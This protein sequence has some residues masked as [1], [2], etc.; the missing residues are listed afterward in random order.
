MASSAFRFR[1]GNRAHPPAAAHRRR[2]S[3]PV[4]PW[5]DRARE[6]PRRYKRPEEV[7]AD[8]GVRSEHVGARRRLSDAVRQDAGL[9][10]FCRFPPARVGPGRAQGRQERRGQALLRDL[11]ERGFRKSS[12]RVGRSPKKSTTRSGRSR[13][14][15]TAISTRRACARNSCCRTSSPSRT[16]SRASATAGRWPTSRSA[17]AP[18]RTSCW[19][20][21][22]AAYAISASTTRTPSPIRTSRACCATS[23]TRMATGSCRAA[24]TSATTTAR[25]TARLISAPTLPAASISAF[26]TIPTGAPT[27]SS[28]TAPPG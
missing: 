13:S 19:W 22:A 27:Q 17:N 10:E 8:G 21:S 25:A 14:R 9:L 3:R 16:T 26:P 6:L 28:P 18:T 5:R 15:R 24:M 11:G 23:S 12:F 20:P 2:R 1:P 4:R 7:A